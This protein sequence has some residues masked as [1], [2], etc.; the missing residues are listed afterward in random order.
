M[1]DEPRGPR[2]LSDARTL[3][4]LSH[5]VRLALLEALMAGPLTATQAGEM[6]GESPTTCS[7]HLRQLARYGFVEETGGGRGRARP[8]RLTH[9]GWSA[10]AQPGNVEFTR[11]VQALDHVLLDRTFARMRHFADTVATYPPEWQSA[12]TGSTSILHLTAA[13]VAEVTAAF[14]ALADEYRARWS[15]RTE[16]PDRRPEGTL[17]VEIIS[18]AY[19]VDS[20]SWEPR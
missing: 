20:P 2:T 11:A 9:T 10:P 14:R 5:P 4:A 16:H 19:P 7:F 15:E 13:E 12:A 6:I 8:W 1:T 3:R 17:P 18:G